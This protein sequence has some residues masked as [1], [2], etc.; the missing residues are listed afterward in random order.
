MENK[1]EEVLDEIKTKST[2]EIK[3]VGVKGIIDKIT[4]FL[5]GLR[6]KK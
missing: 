5:K 6:K 2:Q 3:K 4:S 1:K